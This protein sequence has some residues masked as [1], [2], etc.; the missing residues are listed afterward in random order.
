MDQPK[1]EP[2]RHKHEI[3]K[4]QKPTQ[5]PSLVNFFMLSVEFI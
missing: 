2:Q 5:T 1:K 4:H 3:L